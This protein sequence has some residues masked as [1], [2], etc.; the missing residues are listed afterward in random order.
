VASTARVNCLWVPLA[1]YDRGL[2]VGRLPQSEERQPKVPQSVLDLRAPPLADLEVLVAAHFI[3]LI[4]EAGDDAAG[5]LAKRLRSLAPS[6]ESGYVPPGG[7]RGAPT[8][9][10]SRRRSPPSVPA[11]DV[12]RTRPRL[13][14]DE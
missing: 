13:A 2:P 9:V 3:D 10:R 7:E 11:G 14:P 4:H 6:S 1:E 12:L 5:M 8:K